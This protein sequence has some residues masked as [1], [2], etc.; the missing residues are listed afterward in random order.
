[1]KQRI[2]KKI[3]AIRRLIEERDALIDQINVESAELVTLRA[4]LASS[5]DAPQLFPAGHYYSPVPS[6]R[7]IERRRAQVF[8][9]PTELPQIDLNEHGQME[10]VRALSPHAHTAN[11]ALQLTP[12]RRYYYE[13]EFFSYGDAVVLYS[14]LRWLRPSR[15]VEVGSGFSSAL[16]LDT[17][18]EA[19]DNRTRCTFIEPFPDRLDLLLRDS[20][21]THAEVLV[22]TLQDVDPIIF[23]ELRNGD[24]L[25]IDSS[26][27][28]KVG[29]DVNQLIFDILPRLQS[30]VFVHFHD[31]FYAF[32]YP[33]AWV[34]E[35]RGWNEA[36]ILRAFLQANPYY[37]IRLW[38]SYLSKFHSNEVTELLPY[39]G[40]NSG[41]SLWLERT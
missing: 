14:M 6:L 33:E 32:E 13:N 36:Y 37:R 5:E 2:A 35:G 24:V 1:M 18:E 25:F 20:D 16:I 41:G 31:I 26:H 12:D 29:S 27:V 3:P 17:N 22:T 11:L 19:L 30:G 7:E 39:W 8:A 23:D 15:L 4:Q 34:Q 40:R 21:R 38:N 9:N 28:S 10:L